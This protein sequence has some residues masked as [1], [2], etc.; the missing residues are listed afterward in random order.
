MKVHIMFAEADNYVSYDGYMKAFESLVHRS[1]TRKDV[2]VNSPEKADLILVIDSHLMPRKAFERCLNANA[3]IQ[4]NLDRVFIY[5][6]T[7][8]PAT[9]YR[10][11]F[12][13]M[14]K[15]L[16]DIDRHCSTVYWGIK[17]S[18]NPAFSCRSKI[19]GFRGDC[20][21]HT[22]RKKLKYHP[23][24]LLHFY[25]TSDC[26]VSRLS[27][28]EFMADLSTYT[29]Y[30]C[31]RGHGTA[32]IR[33]FECMSLATVPVVISDSYVAPEGLA[34]GTN[35][36]LVPE[37]TLDLSICESVDSLSLSREALKTY[38]CLWSEN[39]R[40]DTYVD[41]ILKISESIPVVRLQYVKSIVYYKTRRILRSSWPYRK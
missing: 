28:T 12:I 31:P 11:L 7:D 17:D 23:A 8:N 39:T 29:Y 41:N 27:H 16:Y 4:K 19:I 30:L 34:H 20:T 2:L 38:N 5:D 10:G 35:C 40:W 22:V 9:S 36:L 3:I 33:M 37:S 26:S 13:S 14:P 24:N 32:S 15:G 6:E 25:D 21:T 1:Q 18:K